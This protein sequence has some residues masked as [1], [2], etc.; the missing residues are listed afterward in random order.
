VLEAAAEVF[1]RRGYAAATVQDVADELGMLKGSIY[2]YIDS[3]ED[4]LFRV[5]ESVHDDV[6]AVL[7]EAVEIPDLNPL[8]RLLEYVRNQCAYNLRNL[9]RISVYYDDLNLLSDE[10]RKEILRR[11][12]VHEDYIV[13]LVVDGQ[14]E[15]LID[16]TR[17]PR[18]LAYNVF[19]TLIWPYRWFRPRRSFKLE[20]VVESAV[21]FIRGGLS[22]N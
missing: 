1:A 4:L 2:Y 6:D 3:K 10:R 14:R 19:A 9:V 8:E 12:K 11:R 17:H 7:R 16:D 22:A 20:D 18:L 5:L 13:N 15:G 21:S